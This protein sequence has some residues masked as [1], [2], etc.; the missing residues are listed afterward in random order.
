M[1]YG[2]GYDGVYTNWHSTGTLLAPPA[3]PLSRSFS[4]YLDCSRFLAAVFVVLSHFPQYGATAEVPNPW[5]HLGRESVVV[6]FVLSGFVIAYTTERKSA[7]LREYCIA[8]CTRI[9]SVALP[10]VLLGFAGAAFL[11]LTGFGTLEQFYQLSKVWLYLPMHLLFMGELWTVS[12]PPPLLAPYWS[13][14]YE[15]WYYVLFGA[16]F[17]LRGRRRLVVVGSLLLF[18]G[19]KLWLLLPVWASG[20]AAYHWQKRHTIARPLALAGWCATLALLVAFKLASLDMS[21]RMLV[22]DNWPFAGLHLKSAD[23]FLADY[24]VCILVV[25]NFLCAK[26]ADFSALVRIERP[27]RWLASYTFTL[28]LVHA[29]VM[30]MWLTVYPHRQSDPVDVISL[31]IVIVSTT[32]LIGQ[33]TEHRKDWFEAI[34]V[35]LAARWPQRAATR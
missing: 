9:Y 1:Q 4:L 11:V 35:R 31:V 13:L 17:Y 29:L 7:S 28:Y 19:P 26:S 18:V 22:L 14:G 24:I 20:V 21:L 30:R 3:P 23:R 2:I 16:M 8:R 10:L 5:L 32:S 34:F 33:V 12:E 15:V 25:L 6:F 27:V